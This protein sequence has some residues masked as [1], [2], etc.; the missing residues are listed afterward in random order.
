MTTADGWGT[1]AGSGRMRVRAGRSASSRVAR[2]AVAGSPN[3][4]KGGVGV[5][6]APAAGE[7]G[8]RW[9]WGAWRGWRGPD[10]AG[11]R[12]TRWAGRGYAGPGGAGP[13]RWVR[14]SWEV[15]VWG[16]AS[17]TS[18]VRGGVGL[19]VGVRCLEGRGGRGA[20]AAD[21]PLLQAAR[22][23]SARPWP[24]RRRAGPRGRHRGCC[25]CCCCY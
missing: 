6:R 19:G 20:G 7:G 11:R 8:S 22:A 24:P 12:E 21:R 16:F 14:L 23:P 17:P 18:R 4:G 9:A 13:W 25:C 1:R 15:G 3:R 10:V 5:L 2:S